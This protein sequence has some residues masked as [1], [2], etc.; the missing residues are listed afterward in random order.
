MI[1]FPRDFAELAQIDQVYFIETL[2]NI[3]LDAGIDLSRSDIARL[4]DMDSDSIKTWFA[5]PTSQRYR[6][7][8][9]TIKL[10]LIFQIERLMQ[11]ARSKPYTPFTEHEDSVISELY[12]KITARDIA[13]QLGRTAEQIRHRATRLQLQLKTKKYTEEEDALIRAHYVSH[14][15][16]WISAKT[17]RS[18]AA[19]IMRAKSIG[20]GS[21]PKGRKK[22][23]DS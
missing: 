12:G 14:G 15:P 1:P 10:L 13:A 8:P 16:A 21:R 2:Q 6:V 5:A 20:A 22:R 4:V 18:S 11:E 17:G 19:I 3:A 9:A 23:S 7:M